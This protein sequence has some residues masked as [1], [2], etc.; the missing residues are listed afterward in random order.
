MNFGN[1]IWFWFYFFL[2]KS[3][4]IQLFLK[5]QTSKF[6]NRIKIQHSNT[7]WT[8][9]T[10]NPKDHETIGPCEQALG[11]DVSGLRKYSKLA[12]PDIVTMAQLLVEKD[13]AIRVEFRAVLGKI[14][15]Y[16]FKVVVVL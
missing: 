2:N 15:I 9:W 10:P 11:C 13:K 5:S 16:P 8:F 4:F 6:A 12:G 7:P 14:I 1:K 3:Y